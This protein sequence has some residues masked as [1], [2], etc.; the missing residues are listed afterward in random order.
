MNETG[1]WCGVGRRAGDS[2]QGERSKTRMGRN[3]AHRQ[4]V[5]KPFEVKPIFS[6]AFTPLLQFDV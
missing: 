5:G 4:R 6:K 3:R 2:G 1:K